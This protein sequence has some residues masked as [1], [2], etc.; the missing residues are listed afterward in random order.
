MN[1]VVVTAKLAMPRETPTQAKT[2]AQIIWD[3]IMDLHNQQQPITRASLME[4]TGLKMSII[5]DHVARMVD[6]GRLR[7]VI[8]GVFSPVVLHNPPRPMSKT[9]GFVIV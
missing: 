1:D 5:D 2:S 6:D 3:A 9:N 8:A 7:R 4:V